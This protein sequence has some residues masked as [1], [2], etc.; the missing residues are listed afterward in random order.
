MGVTN[1]AAHVCPSINNA[2][3]AQL[4]RSHVTC[5]R[6]CEQERNT[7]RAAQISGQL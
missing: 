7:K 2:G 5:R 4:E 6:T 1:N 3:S